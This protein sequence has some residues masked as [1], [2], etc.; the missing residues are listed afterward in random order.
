MF[1]VMPEV[2]RVL[3]QMRKFTE[4]PS[5]HCCT[6]LSQYVNTLFIACRV[7]EVG[8]GKVHLYSHMLYVWIN[9]KQE[10]SI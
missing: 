9:D 10:R 4:V 3:A 8:S 7:S 6:L 1:Q 5:P 2:N